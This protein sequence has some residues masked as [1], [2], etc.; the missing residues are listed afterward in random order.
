MLI[1]IPKSRVSVQAVDS[2]ST[3]F[4]S[5]QNARHAVPQSFHRR[6]RS[7]PRLPWQP[8]LPVRRDTALLGPGETV[9]NAVASAAWVFGFRMLAVKDS[10]NCRPAPSPAPARAS[11]IIS[12]DVN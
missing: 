6:L 9:V 3:R 4:K 1:T 2:R 11:G 10:T 5:T 7:A 8:G 12:S